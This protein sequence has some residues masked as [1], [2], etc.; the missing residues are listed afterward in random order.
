MKPPNKVLQP[1]VACAPENAIA[2]IG[3][4]GRFPG[5]PSIAAFWE[6]LLDGKDTIS[7]FNASELEART[8]IENKTSVDYVAARGVLDDVGLFDAEF[9]GIVPREA[10]RI[11]PQSAEWL[12][13][14]DEG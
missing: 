6:N 9:F 14:L 13:N 3:M 10:E 1:E 7:H 11:D 5:A 12:N 8:A 2:I 4:S